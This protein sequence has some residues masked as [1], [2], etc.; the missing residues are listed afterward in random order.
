MRKTK[1]IV[2]LVLIGV[3]FI[4]GYEINTKRNN[5]KDEN[6]KELEWEEQTGFVDLGDGWTCYMI[7][8]RNKD[9][10][11]KTEGEY[12]S[13]VFDADNLIYTT[14]QGY[15][16][17]IVN[18]ST[19]KVTEKA[20]VNVPSYSVGDSTREDIKCISEFLNEKKFQEK[21]SEKDLQE[22]TCTNIKKS[23]IIQAFNAAIDSK[24]LPLGKYNYG[25]SFKDTIETDE[26]YT[27]QVV[28]LPNYGNLYKVEIEL[29]YKDGSHLEDKIKEKTATEDEMHLHDKLDQIEEMIVN[30]QNLDVSIDETLTIAGVKF[31]TLHQL[32]GKME[33]EGTKN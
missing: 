5:N 32:L 20:E 14:L 21:I 8:T 22:L 19:G 31:E 33:S 29:I 16:V 28:I 12:V 25:S 23:L 30:D 17:P 4:V 10:T 18:A 1:I 24:P 3:V 15:Y 6:T 26:G 7:L 27:W 11:G 13:Y 2:L 9:K